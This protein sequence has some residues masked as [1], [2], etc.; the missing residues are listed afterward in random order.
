MAIA[1]C[2]CWQYKGFGGFYMVVFLS[3]KFFCHFL[4]KLLCRCGWFLEWATSICNMSRQEL[5][6]ASCQINNDPV[7]YHCALILMSRVTVVQAIFQ[8]VRMP[9][10]CLPQHPWGLFNDLCFFTPTSPEMGFISTSLVCVFNE[11]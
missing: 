11:I 5:A 2:S 9:V 10:E 6:S 7:Q 1:P 3:D 4:L 8:G